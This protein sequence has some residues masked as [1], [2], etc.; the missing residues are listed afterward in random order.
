MNID[1]SLWSINIWKAARKHPFSKQLNLFLYPSFKVEGKLTTIDHMLTIGL[2]LE[3]LHGKRGLE[4]VELVP[5]LA[6][7]KD[8]KKACF[9]RRLNRLSGLK[10]PRPIFL[11]QRRGT[12]CLCWVT[13]SG[14]GSKSP[15]PL[16]CWGFQRFLGKEC[17]KDGWRDGKHNVPCFSCHW[18]KFCP[19][20]FWF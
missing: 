2:A 16:V 10:L 7:R 3:G 15:G 14:F 17:K 18:Q 19:D 13:L 8:S 5:L 9:G 12:V 1:H 20:Q 4:V 11:S 6:N